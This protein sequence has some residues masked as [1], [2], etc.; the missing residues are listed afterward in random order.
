MQLRISQVEFDPFSRNL[1]PQSKFANKIKE[2]Q[3]FASLV[4]LTFCRSPHLLL[5][6]E[7]L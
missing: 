3:L 7:E 5:K 1:S 4:F 2:I 6:E